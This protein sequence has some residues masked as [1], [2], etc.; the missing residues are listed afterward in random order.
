MGAV[1]DEDDGSVLPPP[2]WILISIAVGVVI[3]FIVVGSMKRKLHTVNMQAAANNY[4]K[5][6]SLNITESNDIFLYSNVTKTAK[7]QDN[8][9]NSGSGSST[10]ESSWGNTYGGGGGN[11]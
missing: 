3:A 10:H 9:S 1:D 11:F 4:L 7:P 2:I 5:N 6:G 8:D